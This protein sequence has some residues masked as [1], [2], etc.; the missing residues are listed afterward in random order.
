LNVLHP[1][2]ASRRP[3]IG[4]VGPGDAGSEQRP[5]ENILTVLLNAITAYNQSSEY[6]L[7]TFS[8]PGLGGLQL[9]C[10]CSGLLISQL[11]EFTPLMFSNWRFGPLVVALAVALNGHPDLAI[12]AAV[13]FS[14]ITFGLTHD[15]WNHV[16]FTGL[17]Y[18]L[19]MAVV[20]VTQD[21]EHAVG[22]HYMINFVPCM[23]DGLP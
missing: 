13:L 9:D 15:T 23:V 21:W 11:P 4:R 6:H 17:C 2:F 20:F 10:M 7:C 1:R 3:G 18:G 14:G 8:Q 5:I 16:W 22:A 19:P 12:L